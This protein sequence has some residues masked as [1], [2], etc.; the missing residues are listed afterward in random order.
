MI[1]NLY[2][3]YVRSTLSTLF[4]DVCLKP[5]FEVASIKT[6]GRDEDLKYTT[7]DG[8]YYVGTDVSVQNIPDT[9]LDRELDLNSGKVMYSFDKQRCIDFVNSEYQ[10]FKE[11]VDRYIEYL[12]SIQNC[13]VEISEE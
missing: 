6:T 4:D 3:G 10:N 13:Q 1:K 9:Y 11:S 2:C 7:V 5:T 12:Q 8:F